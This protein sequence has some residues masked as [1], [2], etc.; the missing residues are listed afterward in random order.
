MGIMAEEKWKLYSWRS[1]LV[2]IYILLVVFVPLAVRLRTVN[3]DAPIETW[4]WFSSGEKYELLAQ[5]RLEVLV[6]LTACLVF[7][8]LLIY[9]YQHNNEQIVNSY[10]G[11]PTAT[12]AILITISTLASPYI[13]MAFWGFYERGEG[14][15]AYYC[16]LLIFMIAAKFIRGDRDK[17]LIFY[18]IMVAGIF[19]ALVA[20]GQYLGHNFLQTTIGRR[21]LIP[22]E[23]IHLLQ[24]GAELRSRFSAKAYGFTYNPNYLGGYMAFL[25]PMV[26]VMYLY[27]QSLVRSVLAFIGIIILGMGLVAASSTGAYLAL[28][29]ALL[30]LL[31]LTYRDIRVYYKRIIPVILLLICLGIYLGPQTKNIVHQQTKKI[32]ASYSRLVGNDVERVG[33]TTYLTERFPEVGSDRPIDLEI[34]RYQIDSIASGRGYIWRKS[35]ETMLRKNL[36]IGSGLDTLLYNFPFW[37]SDRLTTHRVGQLIDKPHNTYLQIGLGVGVIGLLVYLYLLAVH[38]INY[39]RVYKRRGIQN[40][41]DVIMLA[42]FA[43]WLGY[44]FQGLSNDSVL[45]NAP[46][47]WATFGL[48][49]NYVQVCLGEEKMANN[50]PKAGQRK[51]KK[52]KR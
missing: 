46:V 49:V 48:S 45:S 27:S 6:V 36:I 5:F 26:W 1:V 52:V 51:R 47:F 2:L 28:G 39:V 38:F 19:Q 29:M 40:D 15:A 32:Y 9:Y 31:F 12:F 50:I 34:K 10:V 18:A 17:E 4:P 41:I 35:L 37:E 25:F 33:S 22:S 16:Y 13:N 11:R 43:G 24:D 21:L 8:A 3:F 7:V 14:A 42:I 20:T 44:L 23:Y 30:G